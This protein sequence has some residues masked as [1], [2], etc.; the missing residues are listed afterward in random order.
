M[1]V[2]RTKYT[3]HYENG[4][5]VAQWISVDMVL[6]GA[7]GE[8][9]LAAL[10]RS[11]EL[12]DEWYKKQN[13]HNPFGPPPAYDGNSFPGPR[14]IEKKPEDREIGITEADIMSCEDLAT[15]DTYR[16]LVRGNDKFSIAY[17]KRKKELAG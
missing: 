14:I 3:A 13:I 5:I 6:D 17:A 1:K 2:D 15:L 8:S 9:A 12:V 11:K 10:D 16:L 4:M 7:N